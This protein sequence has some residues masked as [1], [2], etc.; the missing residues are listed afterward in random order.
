V[1]PSPPEF[2]IDRCLGKRV[3][4]QLRASG[5]RLLLIQDVFK[6]D[7]QSTSDEEWLTWAND[8]CSGAL[9][10]DKAI[11]QA[12]WFHSARIPIFCIGRQDIALAE[13][14]KL[15]E[16]NRHH[17]HRIAASNPGRQFWTLG[18]NGRIWRSDS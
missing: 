13:M 8:N 5:W 6:D 14:V 1:T 17:I 18:R 12:T 11:R 15:F 10:K 4:N 7:A 2:A 9:T 3:P 16:T